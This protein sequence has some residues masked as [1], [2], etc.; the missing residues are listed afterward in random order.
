M[1]AMKAAAREGTR[2][3]AGPLA[4]AAFFLP[5]GAGPGPLAAT[6][7]S[8]PSLVAFAGRL[9]IL[10]LPPG[11]HAALLTVRIAVLGVAIAATWRTLLALI[12]P[13]HRLYGVSGG[14]LAGAAVAVIAVRLAISGPAMPPAGV[15]LLAA[16]AVL[17][18]AG[19]IVHRARRLAGGVRPPRWSAR[20][21]AA[22]A[23]SLPS[24]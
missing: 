7:F 5:W 6:D 14:Y 22:R 8:G 19:P 23:P 24:G 16:A 20:P 1:I 10:D 15:L 12:A 3:A 17:I 11:W 21:R 2:L 9:Q 13:R 4:L 18:A